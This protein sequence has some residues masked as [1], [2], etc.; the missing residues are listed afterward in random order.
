MEDI[1]KDYKIW[2]PYEVFYIESMLTI[3]SMVMYE[4]D[5]LELSI[6]KHNKEELE[7]EKIIDLSQNIITSAAAIS[8]FFWPS[9]NNSI[10]KK[11]GQR[12][13]EAFD[14]IE[15]NVL[16]KRDVRNFIEHFDEKLDVYLSTIAN[17]MIFPLYVGPRPVDHDLAQFFRAYFTNDH[18][19]K[20]LD[21][22]CSMVPIIDELIRVHNLLLTFQND[23]GRL[24]I[25]S[26]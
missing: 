5:L 22:E 14:I 4:I 23:G 13:R 7:G 19:F 8:R 2:F 6:E 21:L 15:S 25:K 16:K 10:H 18:T 9:S 1:S 12:L 3:T 17:G 24:P 20:L 26:S 11:R